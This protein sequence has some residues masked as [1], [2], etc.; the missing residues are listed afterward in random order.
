ML[1]SPWGAF[2]N[3]G[4][5]AL[6]QAKQ[7]RLSRVGL[8]PQHF[9]KVGPV[10]LTHCQTGGRLGLHVNVLL[11]QEDR[12]RLEALSGPLAQNVLSRFPKRGSFEAPP[13]L[14]R[15]GRKTGRASPLTLSCCHLVNFTC[16]SR[17]SSHATSS[18]IPAPGL[19]YSSKP[20]KPEPFSHRDDLLSPFSLPDTIPR[21]VPGASPIHTWG[22]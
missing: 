22:K 6:P 18:F 2:R 12:E 7:V 10:T 20:A 19:G 15:R 13:E 3:T 16:P 14:L 21:E 17:S 1:E 9:S 8:K 11:P 5:R 4:A